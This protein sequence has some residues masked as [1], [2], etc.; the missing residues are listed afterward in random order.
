MSKTRFTKE[1]ING[2]EGRNL[3]WAGRGRTS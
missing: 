3:N 2:N 1:D